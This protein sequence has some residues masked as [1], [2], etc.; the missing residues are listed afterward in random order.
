MLVEA[1]LAAATAGK[2]R[3]F[4]LLWATDEAD[5]D[6]LVERWLDGNAF[7]ALE[8]WQ[9]NLR[10]ATYAL[11]GDLAATAIAPVQWEN[12]MLLTRVQQ[13]QPAPQRVTPGNA[14]TLQL[15]WLT[16]QA[17][18]LIRVPAPVTVLVMVLTPGLVWPGQRARIR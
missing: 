1:E 9:G 16:T 5:P 14:A 11:A 4:A 2:R 13:P 3:V 18:E 10:F 8:S 17:L 7:K 12:G 15:T 6:Q